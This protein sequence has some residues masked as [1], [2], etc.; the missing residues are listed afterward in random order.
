MNNSYL[1]GGLAI[2]GAVALFAYLTPRGTKRNSD[3]FFGASGGR[4]MSGGVTMNIVRCAYCRRPSGNVYHT[5]S[6]ASC[7]GRDVCVVRYSYQ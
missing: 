5:G 4:M 7:S 1:V 3:G 6:D 2:V